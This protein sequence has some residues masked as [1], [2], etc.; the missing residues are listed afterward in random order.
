MA[1]WFGAQDQVTSAK[2]RKNT[3]FGTSL[4]ENPKYKT[5]KKV[6]VE[7]RRLAKSVG[8]L[9]TSLALYTGELWLK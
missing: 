7:T 9:N 1:R 4:A 8:G 3:P 2:K 5:E 6:S